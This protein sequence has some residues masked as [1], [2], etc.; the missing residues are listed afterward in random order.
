MKP[1]AAAQV[2]VGTS[3]WDYP[4][5]R[6]VLWPEDL[7]RTRRFAHYAERFRCV[8]IN[9]S[10]YGLPDAR[11]FRRWRE[12]AP[13]GFRYALKFSR[14][15]SH[16]KRLRDPA[17]TIDVFLA[18]AEHLG[19]CLGPVL[20]Q[21]PPRW[22]ADPERL[23]RFLEAAPKR[24]RWAVELRDADWLC[25]E[26]F[27]LL[28]AHRAALCLH[29]LLPRHPRLVTTDWTYLRFHGT[30]A[31]YRGGYSPQKLGATARWLR[32]RRAEGVEA[33]VFFNNDLGGHA[34]RDALALQRYLRR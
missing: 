16:R 9:R 2:L 27:E 31:L 7:P 3:G 24:V 15:G 12:Q 6:G 22:R 17:A 30:E 23:A 10:F 13:R 28:A 19:E 26:V 1:G 4:H 34:V 29:D 14:Y 33:W 11:T 21:L 8:E 25:D 18:A 32:A 5:W 20:V